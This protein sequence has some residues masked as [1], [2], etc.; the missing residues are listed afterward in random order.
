MAFTATLEKT[1]KDLEKTLADP[2]PLFAVVGAGDLAV[3]KLREAGAELA[4]RAA[5]FDAKAFSTQAQTLAAARFEA[6]Q[7][8]ATARF[9][10]A[11]ADVKTAPAQFKAAAGALLAGLTHG[12]LDLPDAPLKSQV[13][14]NEALAAALT[15]YGELAA[16]GKKLV[17]SIRKQQATVELKKQVK[18]TVSKAK[19]TTTSAKKAAA[20]TKRSAKK[21]VATTKASAKGTSTSAMKATTAAKKATSDAAAKVGS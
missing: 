5:R 11:Q 9:E 17:T 13:A 19:G 16:R 3:E 21:P 18:T 8:D 7:A 10:A 4:A 20:T 14:V 1:R 2:T 15:V 12:N 6:V